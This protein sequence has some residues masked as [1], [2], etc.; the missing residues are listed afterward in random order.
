[1]KEIQYDTVINT[2]NWQDAWLDKMMYLST[3]MKIRKEP[4]SWRTSGTDVC[5]RKHLKSFCGK[6]A[7]TG[8]GACITESDETGK[9][10]VQPLQGSVG[11]GKFN[12]IHIPRG[13]IQVFSAREW[14]DLPYIW[15][16]L[17]MTCGKW[18]GGHKGGAQRPV[19]DVLIIFCLLSLFS[20]FHVQK[21]T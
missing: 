21:V 4:D 12:F 1:M 9:E 11:H 15:R 2:I 10:A 5:C 6:D 17:W 16:S 19:R 20:S 3:G 8:Q 18:I 7:K 14:Q 13:I